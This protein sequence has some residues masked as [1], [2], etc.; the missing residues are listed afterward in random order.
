LLRALLVDDPHDPTAW[1]ADLQYRLGPDLLVAPMVDPSGE[2]EV[3][4]PAGPWLDYW[5]GEP[6]EGGRYITARQPVDRIPLFV[7]DGALI[8]TAAPVDRLGSEPFADLTV[9]S[10][11][12]GDGR[13][14]VSDVD[15]DSSVVAVRTGDTLA[16]DVTGPAQ[17][18]R[19]SVAPVPGRLSPTRITLNGEPV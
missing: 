18:R 9:V 7:R 1:T 19:V 12:G 15:G 17:V 10:W 14:V 6:Y 5:T 2:R 4:L 11:G 13:A 16:V 8:V 3:Y